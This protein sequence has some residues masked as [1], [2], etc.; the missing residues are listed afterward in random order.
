MRRGRRP[1]P[2]ETAGNAADTTSRA[3]AGRAVCGPRTRC[4]HSRW[5]ST[6]VSPRSSSTC[7]SRRTASSWSGTTPSSIPPSVAST[8][9]PTPPP[10]DPDDPE[11]DPAALMISRPDRGAARRLS[12]RPQP[13]SGARFPDQSAEAGEV[14]GDDYTSHAARALRHGRRLRRL[15]AKKPPNSART[16]PGPV[17]HRD[18]ASA[19]SNRRTS[20]TNSTAT[21]PAPS[22]SQSSPPSR[23]PASP[24][25]TVIQSFDHR[26]LWAIHSANPDVALGRTHHAWRHPR[27]R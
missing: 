25:R 27:L 5:L 14:A 11:T 15:D 18:E 2:S 9:P 24:D 26:S 7:T 6:L 13:R 12:L 16:R 23:L 19:R 20:V 10:P 22:S 21:S 8:P 17:Q 1:T 3:I 4:R